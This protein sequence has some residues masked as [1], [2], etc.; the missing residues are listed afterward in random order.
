MSKNT[1]FTKHLWAT[2][3]DKRKG[4]GLIL[5]RLSNGIRFWLNF[6]SSALLMKRARKAEG[7]LLLI[8]LDDLSQNSFTVNSSQISTFS[9]SEKY[10]SECT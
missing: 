6:L 7:A 9:K 3:F 5:L 4:F 10:K 8:K 2:A 1:F